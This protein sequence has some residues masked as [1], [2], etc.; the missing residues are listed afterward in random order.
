MPY[1]K[2]IKAKTQNRKEIQANMKRYSEMDAGEQREYLTKCIAFG[3][4]DFDDV[5]RKI[6]ALARRIH[7]TPEKVSKEIYKDA[8]IIAEA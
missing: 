4:Y 6:K 5:H 8:R 1:T 3:G 2:L 7:S